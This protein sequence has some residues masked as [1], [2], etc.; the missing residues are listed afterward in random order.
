MKGFASGGCSGGGENWRDPEY[1]LEEDLR[2]QADHERGKK[3]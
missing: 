1:N 3:G 2:G